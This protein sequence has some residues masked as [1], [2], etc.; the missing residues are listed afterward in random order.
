MTDRAPIRVLAPMLGERLG[1]EL[2]TA[3]GI[4]KVITDVIAGERHVLVKTDDRV[5]YSY[6]VL[7]GVRVREP[8]AEDSCE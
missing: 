1:W 8:E 4:W 7:D 6:E 2:H 3:G 5:L